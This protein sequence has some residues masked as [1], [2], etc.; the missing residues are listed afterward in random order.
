MKLIL[1]KNIYTAILSAVLPNDCGIELFYVESSLASKELEH[2]TSAVAMIPTLDLINHK[3]L[4]VSSK[5]GLSFDG[6][7]SNSYFYFPE[8]ERNL[9][10]IF[11]RGDISLNEIIL[12]KILFSE[13]FSSQVELVLDTGKEKTSDKNYIVVGD[14]NFNSWNFN[15]GISLADEIADMIE[16]PHVNYLF[17]S[18]DK[19]AIENFNKLIENVDEKIDEQIENILS[20]LAYTPETKE[21]ITNNLN[22]VYFDLTSNEITAVSELIKLLFYHGIVDDV[23]DVKFV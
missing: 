19:D 13:R 20:P 12:T 11:L 6:A 15:K 23:L 4:F 5:H 9:E 3:D 14:E 18:H 21:F 8:G 10:R 2:N 17:A 22:S 16:F 1:P 7:L